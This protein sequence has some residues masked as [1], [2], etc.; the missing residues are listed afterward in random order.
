MDVTGFPDNNVLLQ[1]APPLQRDSCSQ[2]N[3]PPRI[4][5]LVVGRLSQIGVRHIW[6]GPP[7]HNVSV[8]AVVCERRV[9]RGEVAPATKDV[10]VYLV[11]QEFLVDQNTVNEI[12]YCLVVK[13]LKEQ[14]RNL[15]TQAYTD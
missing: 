14:L 11:T 5:V 8:D 13:V 15:F 12:L 6:I 1:T 7:L 3:V 9:C 4:L 2:I 10:S